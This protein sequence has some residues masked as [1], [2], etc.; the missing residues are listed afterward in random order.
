MGRPAFTLYLLVLSLEE[1][2]Q[3]AGAGVVA[4]HRAHVVDLQPLHGVLGLDGLA[5]RHGLVLAVAVADEHHRRVLHQL[6]HLLQQGVDRCLAAPDLVHRDQVALAVHVEHGLHLQHGAEQGRRRGHPAAPLEVV[7][8]V[9]CEP[10]ADVVLLLLHK[11]P[12]LLNGPALALL[13]DREIDQQALA[14]GGGPAV[15]HQDLAVRMGL[16]DL[17][18]GNAGGLVGGGE[19]GGEADA[20]D[21]LSGDHDGLHGLVK[22]AHADG[23]GG[24]QGAAPQALVELIGLNIPV[25][26]VVEI[27]LSLHHKGQG[28]EGELQLLRHLGGEVAATVGEDDKIAHGMAPFSLRAVQNKQPKRPD[29][30]NLYYSTFFPSCKGKSGGK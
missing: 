9:H 3:G 24:A 18:G 19:A 12:H 30:Y 27:F 8:V 2:G 25:V 5:Q 20:E 23:G 29:L 6:V 14:Q 26:R 1:Q 11:V 4:D 17:L 10:V 16:L 7:E 28:K 13:L 15:H 21:V 22:D